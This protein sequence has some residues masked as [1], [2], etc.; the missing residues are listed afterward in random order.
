[1][2]FYETG[3]YHCRIRPLS[4]WPCMAVGAGKSAGSTACGGGHELR[5]DPARRSAPAAGGRPRPRSAYLRGR[6][7]L[8]PAR[9]LRRGRG[10]SLCPRGSAAS[11]RRRV[12]R[13]G[14]RGRDARRRP[15]DAGS[16]RPAVRGLP[17]RPQG[18]A[19]RWCQKLCRRA[20]GRRGEACI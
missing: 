11:F 6:L 8:C 10:R 20:A 16:P 14:L 19:V 7:R 13:A 4:Q 3:R 9:P 5:A 2:N 17:R 18:P 12:R 1:M 15:P